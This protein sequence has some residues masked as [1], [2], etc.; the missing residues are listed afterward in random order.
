MMM[1]QY[2][3]MFLIAIFINNM[4]KYCADSV[5]HFIH[6]ILLRKWFKK[7]KTSFFYLD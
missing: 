6:L 4:M 1:L 2:N 3:K 7:S 5:Y